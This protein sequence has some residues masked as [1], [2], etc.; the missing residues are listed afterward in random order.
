MQNK[1]V[2]RLFTILFALASLYE[3]SFTYVANSVESE[4]RDK[5]AN[6]NKNLD[7][8]FTRIGDSVVYD[9]WFTSF[10]Y[11]EV[12]AKEL[13]LGLDLRGGMNVILELAVQ[14]VLEGMV[15]N[16]ED[17][18]FKSA[19]STALEAQ[20]NGQEDF[21]AAFFDA[22]DEERGSRPLSD[23]NLFGTKNMTD[24]L[25]FNADDAKIKEALQEDVDA[26]I[27]NVYTV[28]KA[29]IDQFGVVQPNVQR[30]DGTGR[31]LVELPG[32]KDPKRVERILESTARLEFWR[33][34]IGANSMQFIVDA[35]ERLRS[36][37]EEPEA[38]QVSENSMASTSQNQGLSD[39]DLGIEV[40]PTPNAG[41]GS[42]TIEVSEENL[43]AEQQPN[44]FNP[45][46]EIFYLNLSEEGQAGEGPII[47][48]ALPKDTG[49]IGRYLRMPEVRNLL[50]GSARNLRFLWTKKNENGAMGLLAIKPTRNGEPELEGSV[51][52][53][54]RQEFDQ[55]NNPIVT[56]V[57]NGQGAQK[58]QQITKEESSKNPKGYV[59]VV[60]DNLVYSYPRVNTEISGGRTE[61]SGG[62]TLDEATDLA[63]ILKAGKLPVAA[64][65]VSSDVV[66]PSLGKQAIDDS[67]TSFGFALLI[68]LLYMIFYYSEAGIGAS[69]ALVVNMFFIFGVLDAFG[70]VL[71]LPGMAGIVLTIGMAG[72]A[73]VLIYDRIREELAS[74]KSI[75]MAIAD[76]YK[77]S[78][79]AILDA[80]LTTLLTAIILYS[81][82]TGPIRGFATTLIIG[83]ASS[84]FTAIFITRLYF[85]WRLK[86]AE[87]MSF[88]T[89][90]TKN[91]FTNTNFNFLKYRK[92]AYIISTIMILASLSSLFTKGLSLGVDFEGGRTYHVVFDQPVEVSE[93]ADALGKVWVDE[94]GRSYTP[95]VKTFKNQNQVVI[96]TNYRIDEMGVD[97]D[98]A[99]AAN[100]YTALKPFYQAPID[101]AKFFAPDSEKTQAAEGLENV[102]SD[103][104][105]IDTILASGEV[106]SEEPGEEATEK[107]DYGLVA[108]RK[109]G[110]TIAD[111]IRIGAIWA[112]VFSLLG[113]FL[114][115]YRGS[116]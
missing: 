24:R 61:I 99:I 23:P 92:V 36:I 74:G 72:D 90:V 38:T 62:F 53:D 1:G 78:R 3:L 33:A 63:N 58:W 112:V 75:R 76:G 84:L 52:V 29:R 43:A 16:P 104:D 82:G 12:K 110:P 47:G 106:P 91:W 2:I 81:F 113:I 107:V 31:I 50:P 66:G 48:Y 59:A 32:V 22:L 10:T 30:L 34:E 96:T 4:I 89:K 102:S 49:T 51:I 108:Y 42:D 44:A 86:R 28:L 20:E 101:S 100:L 11:N 87:K 97:V 67:L 68:V 77:F 39:I 27:E 83:I 88:A 60:L 46:L 41:E 8:E 94:D 13:N 116:I 40:E 5:Y 25:G 21:L 70:A 15:G 93:V 71:T 57:M 55:G 103:Q 18:Q 114:E 105:S 73:N 6:T 109:V 19:I 37:V 95:V 64:K 14:D 17:E 85:E 45:L 35:N 69:L 98:Q 26:A 79:S 56:M 7:E 115:R 9:L 111:D 65:I 80:N 54:A